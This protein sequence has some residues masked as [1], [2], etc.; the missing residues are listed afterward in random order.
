MGYSAGG[1]GVYQLAPRMA[2]RFAA[3]AMMAGHPNDANPLSMRN[4]AFAI[5]MGE[6]DSLYNRNR[7]AIEWGNKLN[8]L[9]K[10]DPDG[11]KYQIKIYKGKG[12]DISNVKTKG[13][14]GE[15][16][17]GL[18]SL[19]ISWLSNFSRVP[20][21]KKVIWK[22]DDVV[23]NR[24]YWLKVNQPQKN[25]LIVASIDNQIITIEETTVNH[26]VIRVN[27][28]IL[29]MDKKVMVKYL[30][31]NIFNDYVYRERETIF[32]SIKEYGDPE[33]IYFGEI[34]ISIK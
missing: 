21:P 34:P 25:S 8:K 26:I 28:N 18:D 17:V 31:N 16:R 11:F 6:N 13:V 5:H 24:F 29:D 20:Y 27:D 9:K 23:H 2:D 33:S 12:H 15:Q 14:L 4:I 30:G 3:A 19:G 32:N 1:D 7:V 10:N 22:Q